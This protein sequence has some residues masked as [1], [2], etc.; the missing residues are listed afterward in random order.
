[1]TVKQLT[2]RVASSPHWSV[3]ASTHE[4]SPRVGQSVEGHDSVAVDLIV[5]KLITTNVAATTE[6]VH[7]RANGCCGMKISPPRWF[8][9]EDSQTLQH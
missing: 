6:D 7:C 9:L 4:T 3:S 1:M 2:S 5:G 8:P